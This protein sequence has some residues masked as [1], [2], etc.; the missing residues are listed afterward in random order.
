LREIALGGFQQIFGKTIENAEWR[1]PVAIAMFANR[2]KSERHAYSGGAKV[3][4]GVGSLPRDCQIIDVSDG[5]AR[6]LAENL[7]VPAEFTIIFSTGQSRRCR[8]AWRIG[9]EFG[10][11][12]IDQAGSYPQRRLASVV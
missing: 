12:F 9:C 7:D 6:V 1:T 11:E 10:A 3:H 8:L 4:L 2:R 5:G